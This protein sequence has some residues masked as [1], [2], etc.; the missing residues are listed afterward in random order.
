[1]SNTKTLIRNIYLYLATF[2]GL[3]M[4]IVASVN[5]IQLG[6]KTWVFPLAEN[7]YD[8]NALPPTPYGIKEP[9]KLTLQN[10]TTTSLTIEDRQAFEQWKQDYKIWDDQ[11]K[12][13]D[14]KAVQKQY[15]AVQFSSLLFVGLIIFLSHGYILRRDKKQEIN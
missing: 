5:L 14:R 7:Q 13:I 10:S 6:L 2:V 1:M 3:V 15:D 12:K 9:S 4:M 8:Y 11:N